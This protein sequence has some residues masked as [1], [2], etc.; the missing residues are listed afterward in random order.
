MNTK[1]L[2]LLIGIILTVIFVL[3]YNIESFDDPPHTYQNKIGNLI[4]I[5]YNTSSD[6]SNTYE[7]KLLGPNRIQEDTNNNENKPYLIELTK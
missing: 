1:L 5:I 3:K 7:M 6:T 2:L 4:G